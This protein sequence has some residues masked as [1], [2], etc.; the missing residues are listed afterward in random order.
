[1]FKDMVEAGLCFIPVV[2][3]L[4]SISS[5]IFMDIINNPGKLGGALMKLAKDQQNGGAGI[6]S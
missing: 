2:G 4:A 5:G 6:D 1:M 3:P